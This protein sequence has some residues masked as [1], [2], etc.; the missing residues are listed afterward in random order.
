MDFS[1]AGLLD[2]LEGEDRAARERLLSRL[3][4]EGYTLEELKDAVAEDRLALLLVERVL[5][6]RYTA[7]QLEERTGLPAS[8]MLRIRRLLGLPEASPDDPVFGEEEFRA[9]ESTR[10]FLEVG[11]GEEAI[12]EI[13]RV[14]GEGM[15]RLA[16]TTAAAFVDA[17]LQPGD[18]E[19]EVAERFAETAE[20]L[21]PAID[22]VLCAAYKQHLAESVRHGMLS[23]AER[24]SGE[25]GRAQDITV[26]F[27]DMV[28]F[29]RLGAQIDA[30]E[31]GRLASKLA[32]LAT[33]VTEPPV[34]LVKTIGDAAMFV[35][36][37]PGALV[38]VALS[39]LEAVQ[40]AELPSLRAGVASGAALQ[41]AGD[42]YGHT[43]N[44]ASRVTGVARPGSVL[45]TQEV[46][47]A[48]P[49]RFDW[50]F[51]RKHK[52]KGMS[53]PVPLYRARRKGA[54]DAEVTDDAQRPKKKRG[55][56]TSKQPRAD[57]RR[58]RAPN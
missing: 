23:R 3:V 6:G 13:T 52:L 41:R 40:A 38:S 15:A 34:R 47:D 8:Q 49:E 21:I 22:P 54:T 33:D 45:C 7:R 9:A 24:E 11:L 51:A 12:A 55:D 4:E 57:R 16:A 44:L 18:S 53:E 19:D 48:A 10:L 36:P 2:G 28:G 46:R 20:K 14:L 27:V 5:G 43:V 39:L 32:E 56:R 42:F 26:C 1:A 29:T 50:S 31:L 25:A 17:F 58:T 30:Q 37:D 35:S